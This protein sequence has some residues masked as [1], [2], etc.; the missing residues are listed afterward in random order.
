MVSGQSITNWLLALNLLLVG[1]L[2]IR[3]MRDQRDLSDIKSS[4][5][6]IVQSVPPT[7][8]PEVTVTQ[9]DTPDVAQLTQR[10]AAN[11]GPQAKSASNIVAFIAARQAGRSLEEA[12]QQYDLT[13]DEAFAIS[14]SYR[15]AT[16]SP[17]NNDAMS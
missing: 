3:V 12:A 13:E 17:A 10:V 8:S 7:N 2:L 14:V 1:W 11:H 4:L 5:K 15:D 6:Q 16:P 9:V